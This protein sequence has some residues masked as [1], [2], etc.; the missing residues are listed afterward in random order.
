MSGAIR[1]LNP[2]LVIEALSDSSEAYDRGDKFGAAGAAERLPG[3]RT[4]P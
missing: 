1:S 2:A 4:P 3:G